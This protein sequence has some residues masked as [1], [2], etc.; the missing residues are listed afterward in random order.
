MVALNITHKERPWKKLIIAHLQLLVR[1]AQDP[2][3]F[4]YQDG[5]GLDDGWCMVRIMFFDFSSAFST[6]LP[7][8]MGVKPQ[9][10]QVDESIIPWIMNHL[11]GRKQFVEH[12]GCVRYVYVQHC[13]PSRDCTGSLPVTK[14][15]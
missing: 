10:M 2:L 12:C 11:T 13:N 9:L 8:L 6:I 3:Q 15:L 5:I 4:M 14:V 7:E 1:T